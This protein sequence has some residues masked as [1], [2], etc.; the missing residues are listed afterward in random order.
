MS[1][2]AFHGERR[3][4]DL[5]TRVYG[6]LTSAQAKR[7]A[8]ALLAA[9]PELERLDLLER[10]RPIAVPPISERSRRWETDRSDP[11]THGVDGLRASVAVFLKQLSERDKTEKRDLA[12]TRALIESDDLRSI[13][14]GNATAG[15]LLERIAE[16][17]AKRAADLDRRSAFIKQL[18]KA[19]KELAELAKKMG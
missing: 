11:L 1:Y 8:A 10:G 14:D 13:I 5:V 2:V 7:A 12:Q 16:A 3:I 15:E 19:D 6:K 9:N 18:K 17:T 4:A